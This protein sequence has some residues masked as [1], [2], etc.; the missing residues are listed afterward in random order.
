M[1]RSILHI[2]DIHFG[3]AHLPDR[4]AGV[5]DL[6]AARRPDLVILSGDL[7]QRAKPTQFRAA[8]RFVDEIGVQVLAV[9]GNHDVP[10]YRFWER[11]LVPL[12]AYRRH[13]DSELEPRLADDELLVVGFNTAFNLTLTGGRILRRQLTAAALDAGSLVVRGRGWRPVL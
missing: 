5:L 6:V 9:P 8:R 11:C 3:P 12:R 13:F 10:L 7:T 1:S 2:S 4:A